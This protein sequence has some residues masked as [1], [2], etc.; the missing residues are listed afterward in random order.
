MKKYNTLKEE[1]DKE[2]EEYKKKDKQGI[3]PAEE[4]NVGRREIIDGGK[5]IN[6]YEFCPTTLCNLFHVDDMANILIQLKK[7]FLV[8][9]WSL[10]GRDRFCQLAVTDKGKKITFSYPFEVFASGYG[11]GETITFDKSFPEKLKFE[12]CRK[13]AI[14]TNSTLENY[15]ENNYKN[16][17]TKKEKDYNKKENIIHKALFELL[18][19]YA[20]NYEDLQTIA[21]IY[22]LVDMKGYYG[23]HY[24]EDKKEYEKQKFL[25]NKD[26]GSAFKLFE[27][28]FDESHKNFVKEW[29]MII[30]TSLYKSFKKEEKKIEH[31]ENRK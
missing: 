28:D 18:Y 16:A 20:R 30:K 4:W 14:K 10:S 1:S 8:N 11:S 23:R 9:N 7:E 29:K 5:R 13:M 21:K 12:I 25:K 17:K 27:S 15:Y 26:L 24:K 22:H 19:S 6:L 2:W 3:F 31:E